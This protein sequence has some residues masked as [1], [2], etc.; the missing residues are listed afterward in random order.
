MRFFCPKAQRK[1]MKAFL[2]HNYLT[3]C[4]AMVIAEC[5]HDNPRILY[6]ALIQAG[7]YRMGKNFVNILGAG[8]CFFLHGYLS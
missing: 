4:W 1:E 3:Q 2:T 6:F 8:H 5:R 7:L